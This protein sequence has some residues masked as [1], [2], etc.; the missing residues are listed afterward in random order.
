LLPSRTKGVRAGSNTYYG[1]LIGSLDSPFHDLRGDVYA[2]DAR[3]LFIKGFSYDG[4]GQG[5]STHL[6]T[7][8]IFSRHEAFSPL[9]TQTPCSWAAL[10]PNL[11][12][13]ASSSPTKVD[14]EYCAFPAFFS[15]GLNDRR[16][17]NA[18]TAAQLSP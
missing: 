9:K 16:D 8:I 7:S 15:I 5:D 1:R 12:P 6:C 2:V 4:Q 14:R 10:H 18:S 13:M 17:D 3:T 11:V